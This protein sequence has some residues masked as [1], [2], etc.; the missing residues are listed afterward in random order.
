MLTNHI[1]WTHTKSFF[2][3]QDRWM[4]WSGTNDAGEL[5]AH[6]IQIKSISGRR[7]CYCCIALVQFSHCTIQNSHL[8]Y[9]YF[10]IR[11]DLG[12]TDFSF[13]LLSHHPNVNWKSQF[14]SFAHITRRSIFVLFAFVWPSMIGLF[15]PGR[16]ILSLIYSKT[17]FRDVF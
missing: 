17:F 4:R 5:T 13:I 2:F 9:L 15:A 10:C 3:I 7:I 11:I 6:S 14:D 1:D 16:Y 12:L 8:N